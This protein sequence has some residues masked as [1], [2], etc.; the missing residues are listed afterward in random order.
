MHL[1]YGIDHYSLENFL[2]S[3][4][5]SKATKGHLIALYENR[6]ISYIQT[7]KANLANVDKKGR[8]SEETNERNQQE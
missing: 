7:W 4:D 2:S 6:W 1:P 8:K 3:F 5:R